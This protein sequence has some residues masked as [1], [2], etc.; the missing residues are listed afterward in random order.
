MLGGD[1][2][3][4]NDAPLV[5]EE[6]EDKKGAPRLKGCSCRCGSGGACT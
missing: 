1:D 5:T 3:V 4:L 2:D 6:E